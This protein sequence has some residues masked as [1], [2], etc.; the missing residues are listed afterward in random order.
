MSLVD[1]P[2]ELTEPHLG[3][4]K[5]N[6]PLSLD[7]KHYLILFPQTERSKSVTGLEIV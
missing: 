6:F 1:R 3:S 5:C 7:T 4:G 2:S